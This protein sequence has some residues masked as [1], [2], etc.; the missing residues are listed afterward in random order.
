MG[1][2][3][4]SVDRKIAL[5]IWDSTNVKE[6]GTPAAYSVGYGDALRKGYLKLWGLQ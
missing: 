2:K 1:E 5:R 3:R 4:P 6:A